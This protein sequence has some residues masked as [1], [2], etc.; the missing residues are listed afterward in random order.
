[1]SKFDDSRSMV[2]YVIRHTDTK[3]YKYMQCPIV[4][5]CVSQS[6]PGVA[7]IETEKIQILISYFSKLVSMKLF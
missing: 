4:Y 7:N 1:M 6:I 5:Q 3:S 2:V